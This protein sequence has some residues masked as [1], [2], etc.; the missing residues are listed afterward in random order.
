MVSSSNNKYRYNYCQLTPRLTKRI[1]M[2]PRIDASLHGESIVVEFN[3]LN[4]EEN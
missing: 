4:G 1:K 3:D 2:E